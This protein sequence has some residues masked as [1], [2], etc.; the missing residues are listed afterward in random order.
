MKTADRLDLKELLLSGHAMREVAARINSGQVFVYPTETVYGVGG[1]GDSS[2]VESRIVGAKG[3]DAGNPMIRV[4]A[5]RAAFDFLDLRFPPRAEALARG[6]WPGRLTLVLPRVA[7]DSFVGIRLSDHPLLASLAPHVPVAVF[8][9]S[10]NLSGRTYEG[11]PDRIF[12]LFC[13]RVDF[14][15]DGGRLPP[16]GPSTVVRVGPGNGVELLR[17]GAV[18][19]SEI[20][21]VLGLALT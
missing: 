15:I 19:K 6:F 11:E 3:R 18:A 8:S 14:I 5:H 4:A 1:R 2:A 16:S 9:T 10:A 7:D 17:E 20:E 13:Q 21:G 12:D